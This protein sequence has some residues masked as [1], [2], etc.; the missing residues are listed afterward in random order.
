MSSSIDTS[1][2]YLHPS[3][4]TNTVSVEKLQ[5]ASNYREWRRAFEI[6]LAVK[7]KL[8][9]RY[10]ITNGARKYSQNRQIYD[11]KQYGRLVSEYYTDLWALWEELESLTMTSAI[12][13]YNTM[14]GKKIE[15][16]CQN[17]GKGGHITEKCWACKAC[18]K[19]GHTQDRC[20]TIVGYP[21]WYDKGKGKEQVNRTGG[22]RDRA[23][24]SRE[25]S[26][27]TNPKWNKNRPGGKKVAGNVQI[28]EGGSETSA[29]ATIT[30]Q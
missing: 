5:G 26:G 16:K 25:Q 12:T 28:S 24:N 3:D 11:T 2:L 20:W 22:G 21:S 1:S 8:E 18:G 7:R 4:G 19:T 13:E 14:Y 17:Y 6:S 29:P 9:Q 23:G 15:S 27:K 10:S 30:A